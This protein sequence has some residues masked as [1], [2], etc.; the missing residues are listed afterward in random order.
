MNQSNTIF[1]ELAAEYDRWFDDHPEV[2]HAQVSLLRSALPRSGRGLEVGVGSGRFADLLGIGS[3]IDPAREM[4]RMAHNRGTG[5]VQGKGEVLPY[6]SDSFDY[7]L[8]MTVICF[9]Q[10]PI[11][12][13][14]EI[15]R[16]LKPGGAL[17]TGFIEKGG[18]IALQYSQEKTKGR[19]L[20][21]AR[22]LTADEVADFFVR[23]GYCEISVALRSRGFCVLKGSRPAAALSA[24]S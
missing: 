17:V 6:L 5:V 21:Y 14:S 22:F 20:Q 1:E 2:Y 11:L 3:G 12:I 16:V 23:A 4:L 9:V 24:S 7:V 19:F 15:L 8:M 18:E 10:D 13:L